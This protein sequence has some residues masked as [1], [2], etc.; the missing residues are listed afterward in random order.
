MVNKRSYVLS[1]D[2]GAAIYRRSM[3]DRI[4]F[5]DGD[6]FAYFEDLDLGL[7]AQIAGYK[8]LYVPEA[9]VYHIGHGTSKKM[10]SF[11]F[12][13]MVRNRM[14]MLIKDIPTTL[15]LKHLHQLLYGQLRIAFRSVIEK[16]PWSYLQGFL[17]GL[18][19]I[20]KS[21]RKRRQ[22]QNSRK[23]S[24]QYLDRTI[25]HKHSFKRGF[26]DILKR[27]ES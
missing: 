19:Q 24:V 9:I 26:L 4:G 16:Q 8:C 10:G 20:P 6:F 13:M 15:L 27:G 25:L 3:L 1:A 12:K 7:R 2:G 11:A 22:I 18:T 14:I 5:L 23:V 21:L 17:G